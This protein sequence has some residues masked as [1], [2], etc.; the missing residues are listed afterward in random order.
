MT[1]LEHLKI[2]VCFMS[3]GDDYKR[4]TKIAKINTENY[5]IKYNYDF[6]DDE[7]IYN[8]NKPIPWSKIPLILKYID[9]YDYIIWI[10]ADILIM[11]DIIK[12]T[13]FIDTYNSYD[14]V[15]GSDF[16]MINTGIMIIKNTDFSKN[17]INQIDINEY[18]PLE[19]DK[20]RYQ[21][22]EQ[23]SFINLYDKNYLNCQ[24]KIKVTVPT[25]FNSYWFNYQPGHFVLHLAGVR[26]QLLG[27]LMTEFSPIRLENDT[28]LTYKNR[29]K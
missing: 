6:I 1:N 24:E 10:D 2:G 21:N 26:G 9:I 7:S 16:R 20:E 11:N 17:F 28:Y 27:N 3:I 4:L 8:P 19:D 15:V 22:W 25:E 14:I 23:G 5:C 12:F 13:D 18:D 29:L